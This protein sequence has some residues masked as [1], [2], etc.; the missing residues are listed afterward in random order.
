LIT[1]SVL[2]SSMILF[3]KAGRRIPKPWP[4]HLFGEPIQWVDTSRCLG[5]TLDSRLTWSTHI[6]QVRNKAAQRLGM[7]GL[8]LN[9]VSVL[10]QEW[11]SAVQTAHPSY[12]GLR[13][14]H[15]EVC[16]LLPYKETAG[17][18]VQVSSHCYQCIL[19]HW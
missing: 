9:R 8:L 16:H 1:I 3:P 12:D 4:V 15:L 11:S 18:S 19:V 7:L 14:P 6:N 10:H 2:K 17:A 13:V 5:V